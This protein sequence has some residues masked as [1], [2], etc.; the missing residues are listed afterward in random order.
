M[1][2]LGVLFVAALV[3]LALSACQGE[4]VTI[5]DVTE[6]IKSVDKT[7]GPCY[8]EQVLRGMV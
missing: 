6:A 7:P 5:E 3:C 1:K 8:T 2:K 4:K